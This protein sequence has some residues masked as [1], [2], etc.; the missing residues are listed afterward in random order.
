MLSPGPLQFLTSIFYITKLKEK[1][2]K[3]NSVSN[4]EKEIKKNFTLERISL[5]N[6]MNETREV[7]SLSLVQMIAWNTKDRIGAGACL[8]LCYW[9]MPAK[10]AEVTA[11]LPVRHIS[12]WLSCHVR[13]LLHLRV[14]Q[15]PHWSCSKKEEV[16]SRG[17]WERLLRTVW[18]KWKCCMD[19]C[20]KCMSH[21]LNDMDW[22]QAR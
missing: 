8:C 4:I 11:L 2:G 15:L 6:S 21:S 18:T 3:V 20:L 13:L 1:S 17:S 5:W 7:E 10:K 14:S 9:E 12:D 19:W 16:R 22:V